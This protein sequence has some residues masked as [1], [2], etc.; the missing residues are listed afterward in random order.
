ML[1]SMVLEALLTSVTWVFPPVRFQTSQESTVP[2][3]SFPACAFCLAPGTFSRIQRIL[4]PLKYASII[5]PVFS[6]ILSVSPAAF[7]ESQYSEVLRSCQ[8]IALWTG[9]PVSASH[10][11]VVSLWFVMP[12]AAMSAPVSPKVE[13][14]SAATPAW[15][16]HISIGS[17]S[18]QPGL[19]KCWVNSF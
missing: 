5:R 11:M 10:T 7:S 17:C 2:K 15:L 19:G 3:R 18:T 9:V 1:K 13:M 6:L 4:V 8:T 12:I 14:A 16:D